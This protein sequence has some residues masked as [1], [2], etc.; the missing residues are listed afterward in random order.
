V[1]NIPVKTTRRGDECACVDKL[2]ILYDKVRDRAY[3]LSLLRACVPGHE[4]EDWL[5]AEREILGAAEAD[6]FDLGSAYRIR[7]NLPGFNVD[8]I[9]ISAT[10]SKIIVEGEAEGPSGQW[11]IRNIYRRLIPAQPID[12][13][14]LSAIF[15][16][17]TLE[18]TVPK[19]PRL[20]TEEQP[21]G[22]ETASAGAA[23]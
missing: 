2:T 3:E 15:D 4:K 9:R 16:A 1:T 20:L 23:A 12:V 10:T 8:Q 14:G 13:D 21:A 22:Q 5:Q 17:D 19:R 6:V 11:T 18:L 7:L